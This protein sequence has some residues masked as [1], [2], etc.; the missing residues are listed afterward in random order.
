MVLLNKEINKIIIVCL[1]LIAFVVGWRGYVQ[2][3][4]KD[5]W[6]RIKVGGVIVKVLVRNTV[7]GR[8]RGLSGYE[9]LEKNE[10]MLFV[11]PVALRH[12]FW[13]KDM[14]F[15]LDFVWIKDNRVMELVEGVVAPK[16]D[17]KPVWVWPKIKVDKVLEVNSGWVEKNK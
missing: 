13:M 8:R 11:F 2:I 3:Y 5:G 7:E 12:G 14:N 4:I 1:L 10:G 17:E 15:D 9:K 6:E 16:K